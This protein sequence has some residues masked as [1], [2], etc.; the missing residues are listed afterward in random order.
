MTDTLGL[1]HTQLADYFLSNIPKK[2]GIQPANIV[3]VD[4]P[5]DS[6][7]YPFPQQR[8]HGVFRGIIFT[9][10]TWQVRRLDSCSTMMT[11]YYTIAIIGDKWKYTNC[12]GILPLK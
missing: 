6:F 9:P 2:Y 1:L 8:N 7:R 12:F 11:V 3:R 10:D 5:N 4:S